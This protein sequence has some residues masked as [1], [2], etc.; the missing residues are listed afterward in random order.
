M[1][2]LFSLWSRVIPYDTYYPMGGGDAGWPVWMALTKCVY[3][4]IIE[5]VCFLMFLLFCPQKGLLV[6]IDVL[7]NPKEIAK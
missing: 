1:I 3:L 6:E 2:C 7:K 5:G 4:L